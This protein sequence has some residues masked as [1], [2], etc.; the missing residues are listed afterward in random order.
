MT[1]GELEVRIVR[2]LT[3]GPLYLGAL[4][5]IVDAHRIPVEKVTRDLRDRGAVTIS[6]ELTVALVRSEGSDHVRR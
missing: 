2:A 1:E 6:P 5:L 3:R 4:P